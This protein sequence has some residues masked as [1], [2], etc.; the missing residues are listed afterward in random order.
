MG[1]PSDG[2]AVLAADFIAPRL[3]VHSDAVAF[4][5]SSVPLPLPMGAS[6]SGATC[7]PRGA[8]SNDAASKTIKAGNAGLEG[9]F[10]TRLSGA[11]LY[12]L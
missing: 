12:R 1:K 5:G 7:R 11:A 8:A 10:T 3:D 2:N 9:C 6:D 4:G